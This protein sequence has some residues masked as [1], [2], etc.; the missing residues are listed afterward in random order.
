MKKARK[1]QVWALAWGDPGELALGGEASSY[2]GPAMDDD[3]TEAFL[4][5]PTEAQAKRGAEFQREQYDCNCHPVR[6]S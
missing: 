6:L 1:I 3:G 4:A 2:V 5:F